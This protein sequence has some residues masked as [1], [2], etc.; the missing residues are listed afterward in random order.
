LA[1]FPVEVWPTLMV[2]DAATE[3]AALRWPGSADAR[4]LERLLDDGEHALGAPGGPGDE[5]LARA[6]RLAAERKLVEAA[7]AYREA[8]AQVASPRRPRIIESLVVTLQIADDLDG[9]ARAA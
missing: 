8:A 1:K 2:I 7:R 5:R 4:E 6:D 3:T 9:C